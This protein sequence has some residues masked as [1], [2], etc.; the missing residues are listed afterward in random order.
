MTKKQKGL[1]EE[2]DIDWDD[3]EWDVNLPLKKILWLSVPPLTLFLLPQL[4]MT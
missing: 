4:G 2:E 1:E 3:T